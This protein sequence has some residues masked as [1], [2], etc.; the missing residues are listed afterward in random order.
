LAAL[1]YNVEMNDEP[2]LPA[3]RGHALR[4]RKN[5]RIGFYVVFFASIFFV[6][7]GLLS[8]WLANEGCL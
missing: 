5:A 3:K 1:N 8:V 6:F 4:I 7:L 2:K